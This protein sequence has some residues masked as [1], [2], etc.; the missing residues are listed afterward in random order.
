M[1][2]RRPL[3]AE[4][5]VAALERKVARNATPAIVPTGGMILQPSDERRKTGSHYTPRA[6]TEPIVRTTL[7]PILDR[8]GE[9]PKPE[10]ILSLKICDPAM[11]SGAFLVEAC[12]QLGDAL[13]ASWRRHDSLP[14]LPPD[15]DELLHARRLIAQRC[16]FGVDRNPMATDLAKLSLWLSTL[17]KDHPF[18]F[19]DH[20][21]RTGDS[22]VGLTHNQIAAFHLDPTGQPPFVRERIE[23]A[24]Q[25][26]GRTTNNN[27]R[28]TRRH[29]G[30][31][32]TENSL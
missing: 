16:V 1:P 12:R 17:A 25:A 7:K 29:A 5:A 11:G 10:Q 4:E 6:L 21:L 22:L 8:L 24:A 32:P 26:G 27:S 14:K 28:G 13:V 19:I 23:A 9:N 31:D 15:E 20:A 2:F 18:T 30:V 3:T